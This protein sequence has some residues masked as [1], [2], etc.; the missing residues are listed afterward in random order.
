MGKLTARKCEVAKLG[1]HFDGEGLYLYVTEKGKYWRRSYRFN[2]K[3]N[4]AAFGVYPE[5]SLLEARALNAIFTQQLKQGIDPNYEKRKAK[6]AKKALEL[7]VNG[8]SPQLF[9]NVAMDWLETTHKAKGWTLKHR[10]DIYANLK[11]Y[12]LPAFHARPIE[13][14]TAGELVTHLRSIPFIF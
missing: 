13:S 10:N 11:N 9:R 8:S 4:T 14:I 12:I 2:G 7:E 5:T 1:K 3:Q 6:A